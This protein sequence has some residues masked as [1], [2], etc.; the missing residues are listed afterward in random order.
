MNILVLA[1]HPDDESLGMGGTI[2]KLSKN[3]KIHLCVVSEGAS[4]QYSDRKMIDERRNA[5]K[6]SGKILGISNYTFFDFPDMKLDSIPHLEINRKLEKIIQKFNPKIVYTTPNADLNKDHQK[7]FDSTLVV[8][9][10]QSS[11]VKYLLSYEF[12][13]KKINSSNSLVYENITNE[14]Q[15]KIKS[16][17][18]YKSEVMPFPHPRSLKAIEALAQIRGVESGFEKAEAFNLIYQFNI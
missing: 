11:N 14:F 1:A 9:R 12:P 8:T 13:G 2:K 3:N 16:F 15:Y 10:P 7:V 17:K 5:C 4:A 6:K 18:N